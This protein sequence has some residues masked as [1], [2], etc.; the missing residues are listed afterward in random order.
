MQGRLQREVVVR[1]QPGLRPPALGRAGGTGEGPQAWGGSEW[2][3]ERS[4]KA[5]GWR[6]P[7]VSLSQSG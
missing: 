3:S 6:L 4:G 7:E 5:R 2:R 1:E